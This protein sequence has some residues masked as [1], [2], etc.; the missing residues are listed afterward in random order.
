[1]S[2]IKLPPAALVLVADGRKAL[3]LRNAGD[4]VFPNLVVARAYKDDNPPTREQGTDRPG[5]VHE[6]STSRRSQVETTDW[7]VVEE[8]RFIETTADS[9][10]RYVEDEDVKNIVIIAPPRVIGDLRGTL[11]DSVRRQVL[12]EIEKDLTNQPTYEI[13]KY[14]TEP[15]PGN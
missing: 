15:R 5:R 9:L 10:K 14:F 4:E 12:T 7:H 11:A 3:F 2:K 6:S 8:Q 13:E 1:M